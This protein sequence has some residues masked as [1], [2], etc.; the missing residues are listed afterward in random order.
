[1]PLSP[2]KLKIRE[3]SRDLGAELL[4]SV[5]DVL[6]GRATVTHKTAGP[7]ARVAISPSALRQQK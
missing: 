4:E 5:D 2:Q 1:M 6:A 7:L 3:A